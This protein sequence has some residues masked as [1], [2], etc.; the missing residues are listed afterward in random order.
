M[1]KSISLRSGHLLAISI[2]GTGLA[3]MAQIIVARVLG[4]DAYG[5]FAYVMALVSV[6]VFFS[7]MG[8]DYLF[9]RFVP[10]YTDTGS[11]ERLALFF[12]TGFVAVLMTSV[13]FSAGTGSFYFF[14]Q[15]GDWSPQ[16]FDT[17]MVGLLIV[18][19]LS[20]VYLMQAAMVGAQ[21]QAL[22][23]TLTEIF[24]PILF[25][26]V[27]GT[28]YALNLSF[29]AVE[30][31]ALNLGIV[32]ILFV[33]CV[34]VFRRLLS[35]SYKKHF[36]FD[37][38]KVREWAKIAIPLLVFSIPTALI[39]QIDTLMLGAILGPEQ[40]GMYWAVT[41]VASFVAFPLYAANT[42][43]APM[44]A[45]SHARGETFVNIMRASTTVSFVLCV[46][47]IAGLAIFGEWL[48][49]LFGKQFIAS[50]PALYV[51]CGGYAVATALGPVDYALTMTGHERFSAY[52]TG[53]GLLLCIVLNAILIPDYQAMGAAF[54]TAISLVLIRIVLMLGVWRY[55]GIL[56]MF[57]IVKTPIDKGI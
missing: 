11:S 49:G 39:L 8:F 50:A 38:Q 56:Y 46:I 25:L 18:P 13:I 16:F 17:L 2:L 31:M 47:A 26:A 45:K 19:I 28:A 22:A 23:K 55:H 34:L 10:A 5:Y 30:F 41:K 43:I 12:V 44:I 7:Q 36:K 48:L 40:S 20:L 37:K 54:S 29:S 9:I 33:V 32:G 42:V 21:K 3:F 24:R 14:L 53:A 35:V 51:L 1:L 15:K 27:V 57:E 52:V 4:V 6:L